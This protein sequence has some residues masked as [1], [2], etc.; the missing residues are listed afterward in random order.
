MRANI[1]IANEKKAEFIMAITEHFS[2]IIV[3]YLKALPP[4]MQLP[5]NYGR[6]RSDKEV[7][8]FTNALIGEILEKF[9]A[10][11]LMYGCAQEMAIEMSFADIRVVSALGIRKIEGFAVALDLINCPPRKAA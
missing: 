4:E 9:E 5:E 3:S 6:I 11:C 7:V 10:E 1:Y 2:N 8:E